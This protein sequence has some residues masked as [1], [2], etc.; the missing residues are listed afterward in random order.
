MLFLDSCTK[1][2]FSF[3]NALYEQCDSI[4]MGSSPGPILANVILTEF[5]TAIVKPLIET[6]VLTFYCRYID[7]TLLTMIIFTFLIFKF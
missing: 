5:E 4:S 6:S 1:T 3:V 7:C 2:A